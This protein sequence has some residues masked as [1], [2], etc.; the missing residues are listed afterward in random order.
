[1]AVWQGTTVVACKTLKDKKQMDM[2]TKEISLLRSLNHPNIVQFL[3]I[4]E[5]TEGEKY[6]VTVSVTILNEGDHMTMV[7][8]FLF[9]NTCHVEV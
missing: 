4:W 2:F 7:L 6:I 9:R 8:T 3:G 1:M 5:N